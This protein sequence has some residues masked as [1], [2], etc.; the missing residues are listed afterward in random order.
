MKY[1]AYTCKI[2]NAKII[3]N[4]RGVPHRGIEYFCL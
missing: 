4:I 3:L 1:M 2:K